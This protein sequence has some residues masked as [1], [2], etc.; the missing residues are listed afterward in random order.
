MFHEQLGDESTSV[1]WV[2][3]ATLLIV[4]VF[5]AVAL[6]GIDLC[7]WCGSAAP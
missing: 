6:S 2:A 1:R 5:V 4:I 7:L 3:V